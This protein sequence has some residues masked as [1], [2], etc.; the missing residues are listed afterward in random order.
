[1]QYIRGHISHRKPLVMA[2]DFI[3]G[4]LGGECKHIHYSLISRIYSTAHV[5][6][7]IAQN[8][9]I[10]AYIFKAMIIVKTLT[11]MITRI[12]NNNFAICVICK[13]NH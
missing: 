10:F 8:I 12:A 2:L 9:I 13:L 6:D 4:C 7:V 5:E 11:V 3:A 1:M